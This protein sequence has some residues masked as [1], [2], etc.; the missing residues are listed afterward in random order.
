MTKKIFAL[1]LAVMLCLST[2]AVSASAYTQQYVYDPD[3]HLT[4]DEIYEISSYAAGIENKTGY[5][6]IF[7]II[8]DNFGDTNEEYAKEAYYSYTDAD[9]AIVYVH[10]TAEKVYGYYIAGDSK[11]VFNEIT[12]AFDFCAATSQNY[13]CGFVFSECC[14][15]FVFDFG[16]DVNSLRHK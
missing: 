12:H 9:N 5:A 10:N 14:D 1:I 6:L 16:Y 13:F 3:Y 2:L 4:D 15:T 7:C 11:G 8:S